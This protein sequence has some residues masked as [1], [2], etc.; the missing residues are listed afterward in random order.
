LLKD[1]LRSKLRLLRPPEKQD[2]KALSEACLDV[3]AA[4]GCSLF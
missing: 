1:S 4:G 2:V 3:E